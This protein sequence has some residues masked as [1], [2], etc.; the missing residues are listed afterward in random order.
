[1]NLKRKIA[2]AAFAVGYILGM[3]GLIQYGKSIGWPD[4]AL[5]IIYGSIVVGL[6]MIIGRLGSKAPQKE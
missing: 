4:W 6:A 5:T 3:I 1:M 2:F